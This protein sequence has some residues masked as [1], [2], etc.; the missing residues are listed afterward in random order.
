M[1]H[2]AYNTI[3]TNV[4]GLFRLFFIH[5]VKIQSRHNQMITLIFQYAFPVAIGFYLLGLIFYLF[6]RPKPSLAVLLIG[7]FLHTLFQLSRGLLYTGIWLPGPVFDSTYFLPWSMI[8]I[9]L[10]VQWFSKDVKNK[11]A[12]YSTI[13]PICL[14]SLL[15]LLFPKGVIP[16]NPKHE[17]IFSILYI[18][19]DTI[20]LACFIL[21]AWFAVF[22]L[23]GK[24]PDRF[25]NSL[26]VWGFI[27]YSISQVVGAYW[28][29][30]G[31]ALPMHWSTRH[32]QSASIWCY[33]AAVLHLRYFP[34][35]N[36]KHEAWF[37]LGG[38]L[39]LL[40]FIYATQISMMSFPRIGG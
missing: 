19:I 14:F 22:H 33:Y 17:T 10:G 36:S 11:L 32:L 25:F 1:S 9:S 31:W 8:F 3:S 13:I 7:F 5:I 30:L 23:R 26:L 27:F 20:A 2:E 24:D 6:H 39:L 21:S 40:A 29:Y 37:S 28:S 35:W 4:S 15:A 18:G 12:V 38:A 34:T 16:P